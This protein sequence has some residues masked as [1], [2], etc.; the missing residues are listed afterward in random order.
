MDL[1]PE[2]M[3]S[4]PPSGLIHQLNEGELPIH[5]DE[6]IELCLGRLHLGDVDVELPIGQLLNSLFGALI[7]STSGRR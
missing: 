6:E 4:I 7:P 5:G 2:E 1:V 3:P